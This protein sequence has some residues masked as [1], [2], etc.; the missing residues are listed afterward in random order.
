MENQMSELKSLTT[1]EVARLCRVSDAT[2]KRWE[3]LGIIKSERT[4]GGHRRFRAEEIARFQREQGLGLKYSYNLDSVARTQTRRSENIGHSHYSLFHLL[5]AGNED[6]AANLLITA[7]LNGTPITDIFDD[8]ISS[9][10]KRVGELWYKGEL[11]VAQEHLATR[12]AFNAIH[13]V[14]HTIPVPEINGKLAMTCGIE[15]DF[16]ELPTHLSQITIENEGWEVMNFGGNTPLYAL[17]EEVLRHSPETICISGTIMTDIE[18]LARDYKSFREQTVKLNIPVILGGR[19]FYDEHIRNRFPAELY[20]ESFAEVADFV[21]N[22]TKNEEI[23][24]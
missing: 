2:V 1:K 12:A 19:A 11:T 10:M 3:D 5:I 15:G 9:A 4:N 23:G 7:Y 16:H 17:T 14:R 21:K 18:R 20:A 6:E 13:K 22:L 8:L 24:V